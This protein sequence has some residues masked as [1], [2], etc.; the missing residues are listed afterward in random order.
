MPKYTLE[1]PHVRDDIY[2]VT[3][4]SPSKHRHTIVVCSDCLGKRKMREFLCRFQDGFKVQGEA[5]CD[6][7]G[8]MT[9]ALYARLFS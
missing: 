3:R 9:N 7:C 2:R 4:I 6:D 8:C 1:T 5:I